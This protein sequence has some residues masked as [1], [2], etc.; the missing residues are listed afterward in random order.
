MDKFLNQFLAIVDEGSI[1]RAAEVLRLTQPTL[2]TNMRKLEETVGSQLFLRT[3]RGVRLTDQGETLYHNTCLMKRLY[4]NTLKA[5]SMQNNKTRDSL[6]IGSG[7]SWWS[8]FLRDVVMAYVDEKPH[9]TIYVS[10]GDQLRCMDQL[11]SGDISCFIANEIEGLS[12]STGAEFRPFGDVR[13]AC[14][15]RKGHPL[16]GQKCS[17]EQVDTYPKV[18]MIVP[19][20][21]H[22]RFLEAWG[23]LTPSGISTPDASFSFSSNS[24]AACFDY[25]ERT[26]AVFFF[27]DLLGAAFSDRGFSKLA[28]AGRRPT[29][30]VGIYVL[31]ERLRE[32][33]IARLAD[34]LH[35]RGCQA[36]AKKTRGV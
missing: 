7:Y 15:V 22:N 9:A 30:K 24:L 34:D 31:R 27:N 26:D 17:M 13:S 33:Q 21:R 23:G 12:A 28:I 36:M 11:L 4:D 29:Q 10:I 1:T 25:L 20:A 32:P 18:E 8:L 2:T 35:A 3:P 5:I 19:E 16:L 14:F 6:R